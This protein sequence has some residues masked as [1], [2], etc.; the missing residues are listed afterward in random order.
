M[1]HKYIVGILVMILVP[2]LIW[3]VSNKG[4]E[5]NNIGGMEV[6]KTIE[7]IEDDN[8]E[9]VKIHDSSKGDDIEGISETS[10]V[11]ND[12]VITSEVQ[13]ETKTKDLSNNKVEEKTVP[14]KEN[15]EK[16]EDETT[17]VIDEQIDTEPNVYKD[18]TYEGTGDGASGEIKVEV[19]ITNDKIE[20]IKIVE[21]SDYPDIVNKAMKTLPGDII[22]NGFIEGVDTVSGATTTSKGILSSVKDALDKARI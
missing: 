19:V 4:S 15:A 17:P 5:A 18:G 20:S 13:N 12:D 16:V 9:E 2:I 21:A 7:P 1:K 11:K 22:A 8:K 3:T 6:D 14:K 10:E